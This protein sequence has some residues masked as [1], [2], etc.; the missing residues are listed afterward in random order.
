MNTNHRLLLPGI[1]L[2]ALS[3]GV[4]AVQLDQGTPG[5]GPTSTTT[6]AG[7]GDSGTRDAGST[8]AGAPDA[9]PPREL[10]GNSVD[11]DA[12]GLIDEDCSCV[13]GTTGACFSGNPSQAGVGVCR[14]GQHTCLDMAELT[15]AWS[16]CTGEVL[17]GLETC[18]GLDDDCDGQVDESIDRACSSA[19]GAGVEVCVNGAWAACSA[20]QPV[21]ETCN[22]L[23]DDCDG[24][25]DESLDRTCANACGPGVEV[26]SNGVWGACSARQPQPEVSN[27]VDDDCDGQVDEALNRACSSACGSG[28]QACVS[29][30]WGACSAPQPRPELCGNGLDDDCDGQVDNG[31]LC[32]RS[33]GLT[34]WQMHD[35]EAPLCFGTTFSSHGNVGEYAWSTIPPQN[36]PGWRSH[37]APAISF[38]DPSQMC[39][40]CDCRAGGDFTYFQTSFTVPAGFTVTSL[41]VAI[42]N[43]DDGVR[44]TV[45]N[46][47]HPSG[48]VSTGS[49]AF[50]GGGSTSNLASLVAPGPNRIVLTHVD[51]CCSVR[52]IANATIRLNGS[53]INPCP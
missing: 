8:D 20:R 4:G 40:V 37:A 49:Y 7:R 30:V 18:N 6:S 5:G 53:A 19:C 22:G 35:G 15:T 11:D 10:C 32:I 45:F 52:R 16:A 28:L 25:V 31:C 47:A 46:A 3:C 44:V 38:D 17:P 9:G 50:L 23:D 27:G 13:A 51:D 21:P 36:H 34:A 43:V 41:E 42:A 2:G 26:C 14:R 33:P 12:D 39:G 48:V 1:V 24:L 29:G